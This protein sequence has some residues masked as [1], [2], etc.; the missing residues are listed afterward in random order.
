MVLGV[1]VVEL[2]HRDSVKVGE[3]ISGYSAGETSIT[4]PSEVNLGSDGGG[5]SSV[6]RIRATVVVVMGPLVVL[7]S[8]PKRIINTIK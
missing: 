7:C 8:G 5:I 6:L 1:D 2:L 4:R 3:V